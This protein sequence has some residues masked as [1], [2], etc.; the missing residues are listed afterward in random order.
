MVFANKK[1]QGAH[2]H[3]IKESKYFLYRE[4][5]NEATVTFSPSVP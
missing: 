5:A 2:P 4:R 3:Y 1:F